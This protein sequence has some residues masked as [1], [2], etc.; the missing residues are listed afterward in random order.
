MIDRI[1]LR[2]VR[3]FDRLN[4]DLHPRVTVLIGENGSGK[5][6]IAEAVAS[7]AW[8]EDEG[9]RAFPLR[10]KARAGTVRLFR[11]SKQVGS[12]KGTDRHRVASRPWLLVYGRYRGVA[13][14]Q[15]IARGHSAD[16]PAEEILG[17]QW[18]SYPM[19]R[20]EVDRDRTTTM[21]RPDPGLVRARERRLLELYDQT[22][23]SPRLKRTWSRLSESL[24]ALG[25]GIEGLRVDEVDGRETL[26]IVRRGVPLSFDEIADGY[27]SV[28]SVIFD[29][30]V[31]FIHDPGDDP[32]QTEGTVVIDEV[33][34]HLHPR[35]QRGV[36]AQLAGLFPNLQFLLTTHSPA[37]VQGA[38]DGGF[39]VVRLWEEEPRAR[40]LSE[41]LREELRLAELGAVVVNPDTFGVAS[42]YSREAEEW[43]REVVILRKLVQR[44]EANTQQ[45][46]RL[47]ELLDKLQVLFARD[48]RRRGQEVLL[49]ELAR[50][51]LAL[52]KELERG[53]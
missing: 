40:P 20:G 47:V 17:S 49:S 28:L 13:L 21:L 45:R 1:E 6:T 46:A 11:G 25:E 15:G 8:G 33:D 26:M 32:L 34:L 7:L 35:W 5:S 9:L 12:W 51:Q 18:E 16:V 23:H 37:V 36:V 22:R 44:D 29:L 43:E 4:L 2:N 41:E 39:G 3:C 31:R 10:W 50:T 24:A 38:I 19:A 14:P 27:K 42:R 53:S 52:I 48:E 30:V